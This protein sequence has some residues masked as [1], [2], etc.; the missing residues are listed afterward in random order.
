MVLAGAEKC[1]KS[2]ITLHY[3]VISRYVCVYK[4]YKLVSFSFDVN[5]DL[6]AS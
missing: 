6:D 4:Q 3:V 2:C 5:F 1:L